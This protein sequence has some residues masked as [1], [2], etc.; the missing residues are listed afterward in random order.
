MFAVSDLAATAGL[1]VVL[2]TAASIFGDWF[3]NKIFRRS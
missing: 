2:V 3:A 1:L